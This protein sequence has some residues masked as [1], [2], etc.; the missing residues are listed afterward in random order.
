[1]KKIKFNDFIRL[2]RG[3]DLPNAQISYGKYPVVASTSIMN[4]HNEYKVKGP[5]VITGRSGSLGVVQY[6]DEDCWPLNTTLYTKD[7]RKL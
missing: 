4:Y 3:F 6:I 5:V 2:Q 7:F 1:M